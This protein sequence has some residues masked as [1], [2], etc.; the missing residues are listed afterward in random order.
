MDSHPIGIVLTHMD[1]VS[2]LAFADG[3]SFC[4]L[5]PVKIN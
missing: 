2:Y 4:P 5:T 1:T 3:V